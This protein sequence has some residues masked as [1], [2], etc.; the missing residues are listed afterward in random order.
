[1]KDS[2]RFE[3]PDENPLTLAT[4]EIFKC[5]ECD[6]DI[7]IWTDEIGRICGLVLIG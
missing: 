5:P 7:E 3:Y 6:V 1:M 4:P 2:F